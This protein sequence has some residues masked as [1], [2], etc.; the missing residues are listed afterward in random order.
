MRISYNSIL[1]CFIATL[2]ALT[3]TVAL[4]AQK[5][6]DKKPSGPPPNVSVNLLVL[7]AE[8]KP[9]REIKASDIKIFEDGVEQKI[10]ELKPRGPLRYLTLLFD[11]TGSMRPDLDKITGL[12]SAFSQLFF[13]NGSDVKISVIR[14]VGRD[15]ISIEQPWTTDKVAIEK[16]IENLY[17]EGGQSAV[18]D[19]LYLAAENFPKRTDELPGQNVV[20]LISDC[21][22]RDSFYTEK[23][24]LEKLKAANAQVFVASFSSFAPIKPKD[25]AYLSQNLPLETGGTEYGVDKK[26]F[27]K[28]A[29]ANLKLIAGEQ[30]SQYIFTYQ[31]TNLNRDGQ[32]RK[33]TVQ[34][35]DGPNGEKRS[36]VVRDSFSVPKPRKL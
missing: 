1:R 26:D 33:L 30:M 20:L 28:S 3:F 18:L 10:D 11:N 8:G 17:V 6:D 4:F 29:V 15:K 16:A 5:K 22:D 23:Q 2:T 7:N 36:G 9:V 19:A 24:T 27:L 34:I 31:S 21:E 35:A 13:F 14:F 12:R 32:P 25:A